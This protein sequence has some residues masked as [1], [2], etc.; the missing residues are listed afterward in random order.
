M[1]EPTIVLAS[2]SPRRVDLLGQLLGHSRFEMT[3]ADI[4]ETEVAQGFD[5][6]PRVVSAVARAKAAEV[7]QPAT[8]VVAADTVVDHQGRILGKPL[9]RQDATAMLTAMRGDLVEVWSA[10]VV[11]G[12]SGARVDEVVGSR[13]IIGR[14]DDA[15]IATYV[16]SGAAD[17]K[18]GALAV[19]DEA[20]RFIDRI[21]GCRANVYGLPL[22]ATARLLAHFG[23]RPT[24]ACPGCRD[25]ELPPD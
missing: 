22:C 10:V 24:A 12:P 3:P 23:V 4:D 8:T 15:A 16:E 20:R 25:G 21:E 19:Q 11:T 13:L 14:P 7:W 18:A 1:T 5:T 2:A 6:A 9:D 17:D